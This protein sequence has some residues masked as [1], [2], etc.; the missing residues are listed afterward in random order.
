MMRMMVR[1]MGMHKMP[2]MPSV[3]GPTRMAESLATSVRRVLLNSVAGSVVVI[4]R[5]AS[6]LPSVESV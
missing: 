6:V 2:S 4:F 5:H 3:L 1:R